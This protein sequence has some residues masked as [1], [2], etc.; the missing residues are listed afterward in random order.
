MSEIMRY[1]GNVGQSIEAQVNG[2][3]DVKGTH[4]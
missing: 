3:L 4:Q 1:E 2:A